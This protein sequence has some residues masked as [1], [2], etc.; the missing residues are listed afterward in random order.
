MIAAN[1]LGYYWIDGKEN[2]ADIISKHWSY[3]QVWHLLKRILFYSGDRINMIHRNYIE[4]QPESVTKKQTSPTVNQNTTQSLKSIV[5][6][7]MHS[8]FMPYLLSHL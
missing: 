4:F 7:L 1:V 2:P 8:V 6:K 5:R 3:P